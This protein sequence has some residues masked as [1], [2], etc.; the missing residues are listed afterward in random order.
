MVFADMYVHYVFVQ[1]LFFK[2]CY[3]LSYSQLKL[4]VADIY[5]RTMTFNIYK[6]PAK[7]HT[8]RHSFKTWTQCLSWIL[9][10]GRTEK[11]L[12]GKTI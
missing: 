2:L 4:P 12:N 10:L 9:I 5:A 8:L 3:V 1:V 11:P 7:K 6:F